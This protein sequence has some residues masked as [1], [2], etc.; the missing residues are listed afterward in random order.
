MVIGGVTNINVPGDTDT[1]AG[2]ITAVLNFQNGDFT[3]N[4]IGRYLYVVYSA[5][6]SVTNSFTVTNAAY[7]QSFTGS[8]VNNGTNVP[9]AIVLLFPPPSGQ[10]LGQPLAGV[11]ANNS[12]NFTLQA[13]QGTYAFLAA[14]S[15]FL[16]N[17]STT[18]V[19][20]LSNGATVANLTLI[21]A[22]ASISGTLVDATNNSIGLPGVFTTVKSS[23]ELIG[24]GFTGSNGNFTVGVTSGQWEIG[25]N[26]GL[27]VHGYAELGSSPTF[28]AGATGATVAYTKATALFYGSV[29]DNLGNPLPGIAIE[30]YGGNNQEYDSDGYANAGGNYVTAAVGGLG[31]GELWQ[32][33]VDNSGSFTNYVFSQP[34][35]EQNG[36]TNVG[37][38]QAVEV[39]WAALPAIGQISGYVQDG[40]GNGIAGVGVNANA[41]INGQNFQAHADTDGNGNYSFNVGSGIWDVSVNCGNG[42]DGLANLG[43]Y[44]CPSD[45]FVT[46]SGVA[47]FI[48]QLCG[49][50]QITTTN[51]PNAQVGSYYDVF[52]NATSCA[53]NFTWSVN[54]PQDFPSTLTLAWDGELYGTPANAGTYNFSVNATDGDGDSTNQ[55][56]SLTINPGASPSPLEVTTTSLTNGTNGVFYSQQLQASG[57][58][59]PYSWS[60]APGVRPACRRTW[61]WGPMGS[62]PGPLT[63]AAP[64]LN[65]SCK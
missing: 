55:S 32:M 33:D 53:G 16:Y 30:A 19:L 11:V 28:D 41:Q 35:F 17:F 20:T 47:D 24:L 52:L 8:V 5:S 61:S 31:N 21:N 50:V 56:L 49:T 9:D 44:N 58:Q 38:G 39:N 64:I 42:S 54:D 63:S 18:P 62:F 2:H 4:I 40:N 14:G 26:S 51:L 29:K 45:D 43:N 15:N 57:G 6:G 25:G 7:G 10:G 60:L 34:A 1:V 46:N 3:Q 27:I 48:A 65:S 13:P 37:A 23:A 22:A 36:G 12:G 59:S